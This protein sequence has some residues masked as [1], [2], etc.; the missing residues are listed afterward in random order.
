M[1]LRALGMGIAAAALLAACG[2]EGGPAGGSGHAAPSGWLS[3]LDAGLK[4]SAATGK[5]VLV[6]FGADW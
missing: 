6:D 5:P 1:R 3:D 4:E 2:G